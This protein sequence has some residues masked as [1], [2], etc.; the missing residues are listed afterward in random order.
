MN[1]KTETWKGKEGRKERKTE[2]FNLQE[3]NWLV[4]PF[5]EQLQ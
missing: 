1:N 5:T 3:L 2:Q 4:F